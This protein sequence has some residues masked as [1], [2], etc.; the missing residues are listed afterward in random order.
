MRKP[1]PKLLILS[2]LLSLV[3]IAGHADPAHAVCYFCVAY[4]PCTD[5]GVVSEGSICCPAGKQPV[6][7]NQVDENGCVVP[8]TPTRCQ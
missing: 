6:C 4:D 1:L 3:L 5:F 2:G 7:V 8:L